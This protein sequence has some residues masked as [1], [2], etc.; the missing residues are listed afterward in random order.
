[1]KLF[2]HGEKYRRYQGV[3]DKIKRLLKLRILERLGLYPAGKSGLAG[4]A[5][6]GLVPRRNR[7]VDCDIHKVTEILDGSSGIELFQLR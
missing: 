6:C 5:D 3:L 1:L 7:E 4:L 2:L